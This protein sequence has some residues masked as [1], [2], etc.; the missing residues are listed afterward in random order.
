MDFFLISDILSGFL[1]QIKS[2]SFVFAE[3]KLKTLQDAQQT[4]C[5]VMPAY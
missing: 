2:A 4:L 5:V 1:S 3:P